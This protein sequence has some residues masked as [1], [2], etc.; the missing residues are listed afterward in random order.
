MTIRA[1]PIVMPQSARLN[2][3]Q[4]GVLVELAPGDL[5]QAAGGT[6]AELATT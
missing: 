5:V 6:V 1:A 3:G 2:A 4:R